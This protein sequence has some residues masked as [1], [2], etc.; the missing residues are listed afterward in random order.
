M[1]AYCDLCHL[2]LITADKNA[3]NCETTELRLF[4]LKLQSLQLHDSDTVA[5][6]L[7]VSMFFISPNTHNAGICTYY[8]LNA[9]S[10]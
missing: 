2:L 4:S 8:H 9:T 10:V 5:V 7:S 3:I 6:K 1:L